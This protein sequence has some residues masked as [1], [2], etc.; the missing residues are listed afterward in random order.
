MTAK[1]C[2]RRPRFH[3]GRSWCDVQGKIVSQWND[4][5]DWRKE[6]WAKWKLSEPNIGEGQL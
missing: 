5:C 3:P 1:V 4:W 6:Q 2:K